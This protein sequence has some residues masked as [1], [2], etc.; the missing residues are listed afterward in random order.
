M[1]NVIVLP[2]HTQLKVDGDAQKTSDGC[3][4]FSELYQQRSLIFI[5]LMKSHPEKSWRSFR[6]DTGEFRVGW[7]VAGMRLQSGDISF[8]L[9][10]KFWYMLEGIETRRKA[11][12]FDG[13]TSLDVCDRLADW[14]LSDIF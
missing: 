13:H 2:N 11:P 12:P 8:H 3:H 9:A 5:A 10:E 4:D 6:H 7:F 14:I 1:N